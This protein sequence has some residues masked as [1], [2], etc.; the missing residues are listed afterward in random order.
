M[1]TTAFDDLLGAF[2]T[3]LQLATAVCPNVEL[4]E[5]AEPLPAG[6]T[7]SVLITLGSADP[8][9]LGGIEGN[10]IDWVTQINVH[11]FASNAGSSAR[12]AVNTLA[13]KVYERLAADKAVGLPAATGTFIGEPQF[14][15]ETDKADRRYARCTLS[16]R[17][18]HRT[19]NL[20]LD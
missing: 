8:Q 14:T 19:A 6:R 7:E 11:C 17:V 13:R 3:R 4:D 16:Y 1:S 18:Q 12:P 10:P 20:S 5:D 15:W 9:P 2:Q